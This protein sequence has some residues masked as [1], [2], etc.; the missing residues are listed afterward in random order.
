[1]EFRGVSLKGLS[2]ALCMAVL[3][4]CGGN[5]GSGS[6]SGSSGGIYGGSSSSSSSGGS[7]SSSSSGSSSGGASAA[8]YTVTNLVADISGLQSGAGTPATRLDKNL[9]NPWGL[10]FA[11]SAPVWIANNGSQTST[12][13]DGDGM[14]QKGPFVVPAGANGDADPTGIVFN[15]TAADFVV[16]KSGKSGGSVFI[17]DGEGGTIAGWS[18]TVD[19]VNAVTVY[20]DAGGAVYKG[21]AEAANGGAN[22][23]YATDFHNNKVDVFDRTFAKVSGGSNFAFKDPALPAGYA[24][25]GIAALTVKG[26]LQLYVSYAK[27]QAPDNH[28]NADGAGLGIVDVYTTAGVLVKTL[29]AAGGALDA[30]WGMALAP[31]DFGAASNDLLVGNFGDGRINVYDPSAGT[32]VGTLADSSNKP[33]ALSGLWGIAFGNDGAGLNQP[34]NTLFFTA[35]TNGEADG[36][37]GRIDAGPGAPNFKPTVTLNAP[38][39]TLKG[40]VTLTATATDSVGIKQVQFMANGTAIGTAT[41]APFSVQWDTT[42]V[43]DG[44][45]TLNATATDVD[46]NTGTAAPQTVTVTNATAPAA[47]TLTQLQTNF[48][49]PICSGCHSGFGS[50]LPG[51]QNLTAGNSFGQIVNVPSVEQPALFRIKPNDPTNSYLI[52]K[53][54][55]AQ[56]ISGS[57]MPLGCPNSQPCLTQAQ[58]DMFV[59]WVNAGALNN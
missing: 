53:I 35:G 56:G 3:S 52:Q 31:A 12:L 28:D 22:F 9:V 6:S 41:T 7:S 51:S 55:G 8:P 13:Y 2:F 50:S 4:A 24:P 59:S 34:H 44:S 32:F 58:I 1:M 16:S 10:V 5:D 29:V 23:L 30:P 11:P 45:V 54:E 20:S 46:G 27:Q 47:T 40:T 26:Q 25:F 15:G 49:T 21:L 43:A 18:P 19:P 33:I 38:S 37:Y 42:K 36:V 48:F 14:V 17:F 57:R 39:G